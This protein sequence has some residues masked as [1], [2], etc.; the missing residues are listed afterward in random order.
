MLTEYKPVVLS[1][2]KDPDS[3]KQGIVF[4]SRYDGATINACNAEIV[5]PAN[6]ARKILNI[7][8]LVKTGT[9]FHEVCVSDLLSHCKSV[10]K[11][12]FISS[13]G[14]PLF[15]CEYDPRRYQQI[16]ILCSGSSS[17]HKGWYGIRIKF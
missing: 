11:I 3:V 5:Q 12:P 16:H 13:A 10:Y 7:G 2:I 14:C 8:R 1:V 15:T 4:L 6:M 17:T 9:V